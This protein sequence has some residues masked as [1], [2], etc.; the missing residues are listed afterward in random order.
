MG[1]SNRAPVLVGVVDMAIE[2]NCPHCLYTY[3]L[4]DEFGGKRATC[5]NPDCRQVIAI[6]KPITGP[7]DQLPSAADLEAAALSALNEDTSRTQEKA[8]EKVIHMTCTICEHKWTEPFSKAGKNTLCQNPDC[9]QRIKVPEP[10]ADEEQDWRQM[11]TRLPSGAKQNFEKL[12]GVEDAAEAK[13]VTGETLRR[14]GLTGIEIEPR[15][16]KEKFIIGLTVFSVIALVGFGMW[17]LLRARSGAVD[18]RLMAEAL[19]SFEDSKN[20]LAPTDSALYSAVLNNAAGEY[21][22]RHNDAQKLK[23]AHTFYIKARDNIKDLPPIPEK[24]AVATELVLAVVALGGSGEQIKEQIRFRWQPDLSGGRLKINERTFTIH[25]ELV[26][27]LGLFEQSDFDFKIIVARRL[28]RELSKKGQAALAAE[29]IPRLMFEEP[30]RDEAQAIVALEIYRLDKGSEVAKRI[31]EEL[32]AQKTEELK[33]G[34]GVW[35]IRYSPSAYTL[36]AVNSNPLPRFGEALPA[37][38]EL[39]DGVRTAHVGIALLEGNHEEAMKLAQRTRTPRD[40]LKSLVLCCE[41]MA[42]PAPALEAAQNLIESVKGVK[43][44]NLSQ[45]NILRLSQIAASAGLAAQAKA[46]ANSL[47]DEGL[48]AWALGDIVHLQMAANAK[49][50]VD[51]N[52]IERPEDDKKYKLGHMWAVYWMARRN[53][54]ESGDHAA[55]RKIMDSWPAVVQPFGLAGEALGLQDR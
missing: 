54:A 52:S 20:E 13:S 49:G 40:Q 55:E 5:K 6:P 26:H 24:Y 41:W 51:A 53:T 45:S 4:K 29:N 9:R 44:V 43:D 50:K 18:D 36:F 46:M 17:Y 12:E 33:N 10:K 28:A 48:R 47:S 42:N 1:R 19:K 15:T 22:L 16:L 32:R 27:S 7:E 39:N 35:G 2:F 31:S 21:A 38:G 25:N 14:V 34:K 8:A 3:K 23:E 30:D 11:K 37:G